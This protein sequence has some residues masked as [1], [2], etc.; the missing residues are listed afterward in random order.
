MEKSVSARSATRV[1]KKKKIEVP[2][3]V[4]VANFS[5]QNTILS[6]TRPDGA[7]LFHQSAGMLGPGHQNSKRRTP[8]SAQLCVDKVLKVASEDYK[9][10][11]LEL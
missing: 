11:N 2:E 6:L 5:F 8:Y 10:R 1:K 7:V 4:L 3:A 9:V